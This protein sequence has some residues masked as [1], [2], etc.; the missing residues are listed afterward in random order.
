MAAAVA[1]PGG[2][3]WVQIE[4]PVARLG[5]VDLARAL[6]LAGPSVVGRP[7]AGGGGRGRSPALDPAPAGR[8][9]RLR[10]PVP[11]RSCTY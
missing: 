10:V 6:E 4:S 3:E 9:R 11:G 2:Q 7:A 8:A 5:D 1:D